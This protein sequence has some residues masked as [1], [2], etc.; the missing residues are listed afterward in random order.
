MLENILTLSD[1]GKLSTI[2]GWKAIMF[3]NRKKK[4][5]DCGKEQN[6]K[7]EQV[8]QQDLQQEMDPAVRPGGVFIVQ[9]LMK[10]K[11]EMPSEERMQEVLSRHLGR[12]EQFGNRDKLKDQTALFVAWDH[13]GHFQDADM[14]VQLMI[15]GCEQFQPEKIDDFK[16]SQMWDYLED[17]ER[18]LSECRYQV[19][20]SDMMGGS[21]PT[22]ERA[23]MLM[24]Y[25]EALV[26][27]FP[28]CE[29]VYNLNSGKLV[30]ADVIRQGEI[31]GLDRF[32]RYA[33]NARFFNVQG[34]DDSMVD[35]LGLSL[36][37]IEDLQ[38][39]FHDMDPNWVVTHAYNMASYL[40]NND[41]PI[42]D[43]DT[44]DGI[45][46]GRFEKD[47]QWRCQRENALIQ[48]SRM[49]IDVCMGEYASGRRD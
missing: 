1:E 20:A 41:N 24:D 5:E 31:S 27:L 17:R 22:Q 40:L 48:P 45:R 32:I 11:C 44:I 33:V 15:A 2:G 16:R 49:V 13:I 30:Q 14:P 6:K 7:T 47:I 38:Y 36:L 18:I 4:K 19:L 39:H 23:N 37:Y 34:T 26:E 12:I 9:L 3:F 8:F 42:K 10:E 25:L 46:E 21:L 35:T 28:W 29:A 43:G